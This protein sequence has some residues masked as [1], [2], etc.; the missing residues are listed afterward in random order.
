MDDVT[1][2]VFRQIVALN[3]RPDAF[4]TEFTNCDGLCSPGRDKLLPRFKF[5]TDQHPIVAQIWGTHPETY[6]E[7]AKLIQKMGF[8]GIDINMGCPEHN[9][10]KQGACCALIDNPEL[11]EQIIQAVKKGAPKLPVS[12]KTRLGLKTIDTESWIGFLLEQDLAAITI[13]G[14]TA[15][16][17][18]K[19]PVHW[20]EIAKAVKLRN[21]YFQSNI[22]SASE[23]SNLLHQMGDEIGNKKQGDNERG[24]PVSTRNE[25]RMSTGAASWQDPSSAGPV[26]TLIIGNGD[27][28]SLDEA[29]QKIAETGID[30]IMIGRGIFANPWVFEKTAKKHSVNDKINLAIKHLRL[31]DKTYGQ[32]KNYN[33]M[34][35]FFKSYINGFDG[36]AEFRATLMETQTALEAKI[37]LKNHLAPST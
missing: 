16:E 2:V 20:D 28:M 36:A 35:K 11:A 29:N 4:F 19:T 33:I 26:K 3:S 22:T 27:I 10:I 12:V 6:F 18:S 9:V 30:G 31:F 32:T 37:L 15:K 13:H 34:K 21:K 23:R 7:T 14:R 5:T 8:D 24:A 25:M 1:D 17:M